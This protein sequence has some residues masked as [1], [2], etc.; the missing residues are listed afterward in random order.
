MKLPPV[1]IKQIT[2]ADPDGLL[3]IGEWPILVEFKSSE[4]YPEYVDQWFK[5]DH[6]MLDKNEP[7]DD[8]YTLV[9][10]HVHLVCV[11]NPEIKID[12]YVHLWELKKAKDDIDLTKLE[13]MCDLDDEEKAIHQDML[14]GKYVSIDSPAIRRKYSEIFRTFSESQNNDKRRHFADS[15]R[16][17]K[18]HRKNL[19]SK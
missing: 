18:I 5:I 16:A 9:M 4:D 1:K 6:V 2:G 7:E 11:T 8:F 19:R 15:K 13:P 12:G 17:K 14:D 3:T 10:D